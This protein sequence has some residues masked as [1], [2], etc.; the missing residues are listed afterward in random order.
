[1]ILKQYK[2]ILESNGF[3]NHRYEDNNTYFNDRGVEINVG[4]EEIKKNE[5]INYI[6]INNIF[7]ENSCEALNLVLSDRKTIINSEKDV[8]TFEKCVLIANNPCLYLEKCYKG[9]SDLYAFINRELSYYNTKYK[10]SLG[11]SY[12]FGGHEESDGCYYVEFSG[13][14]QLRHYNIEY[15]TISEVYTIN[16][17]WDAENIKKI[18]ITNIKDSLFNVKGYEDFLKYL[19]YS[20]NKYLEYQQLKIDMTAKEFINILKNKEFKDILDMEYNLFGDFAAVKHEHFLEAEAYNVRIGH[21]LFLSSD[22]KLIKVSGVLNRIH[23]Q[24]EKGK[25]KYE[26]I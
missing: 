20:Y 5:N 8:S 13:Y 6:E 23:D 10:F 3:Y 16:Y 25:L 14:I 21:T 22:N 9:I 11:D 19:E 18:V 15:D 2:K 24:Y 26:I 4:S 17:A 12:M 1:M 7:P